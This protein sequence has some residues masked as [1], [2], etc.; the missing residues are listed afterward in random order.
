MNYKTSF[1]NFSQLTLA[2][3]NFSLPGIFLIEIPNFS[4]FLKPCRNPDELLLSKKSVYQELL[5]RK[6]SLHY[7]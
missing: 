5:S 1:P 3:P 2:F 4:Q 7:E 6:Q